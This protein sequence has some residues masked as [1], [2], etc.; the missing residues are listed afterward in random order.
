MQDFLVLI[1]ESVRFV[2]SACA[3][4]AFFC[5]LLRNRRS[6][7]P[8]DLADLVNRSLAASMIPVGITL[9]VCAFEPGILSQLDGFGIYIAVAGLVLIYISINHLSARI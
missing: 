2:P 9:L 1:T 3:I 6:S 7:Q 4:V 8:I 5:V